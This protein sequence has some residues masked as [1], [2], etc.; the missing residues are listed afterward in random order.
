M[1]RKNK[2]SEKIGACAK[3][4]PF[5]SWREALTCSKTVLRNV[6]SALPTLI[7]PCWFEAKLRQVRFIAAAEQRLSLSRVE[8]HV[9]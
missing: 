2:N 5:G 9:G 6:D 1:Y 4:T 3:N 7:M 8:S